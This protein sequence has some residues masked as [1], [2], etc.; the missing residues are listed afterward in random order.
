[1]ER[2]GL[3]YYDRMMHDMALS[4]HPVGIC[5]E[6]GVRVGIFITGF[7]L[8]HIISVY[9]LTAILIELIICTI[10]LWRLEG[11]A[12][13]RRIIRHGYSCCLGANVNNRGTPLIQYHGF[14]M[15]TIGD[16]PSS[17]WLRGSA[18][19]WQGGSGNCI[20]ICGICSPLRYQLSVFSTSGGCLQKSRGILSAPPALRQ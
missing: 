16:K 2:V 11:G 5:I 15:I 17:C 19:N 1:M 4:H 12:D 13:N 18:I 7:L 3:G 20:K 9:F 14:A 10:Y 8:H 6:D